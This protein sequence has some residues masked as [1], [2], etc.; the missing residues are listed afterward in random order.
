MVTH[1][2]GVWQMAVVEVADPVALCL[3]LMLLLPLQRVHTLGSRFL[4]VPVP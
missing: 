2:I 1:I 4:V 3:T